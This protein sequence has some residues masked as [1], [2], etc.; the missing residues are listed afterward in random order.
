MAIPT[1]DSS[2]AA[3][4]GTGTSLAVPFPGTVNSGDQLLLTYGVSSATGAATPSGWTLQKTASQGACTAE[5]YTKSASGSETGTLT[6]TV[7]T[8]GEPKL[9]RMYRSTDADSIEAIVSSSASGKTVDHA[10]IVSTD[11]DRLAMTVTSINDDESASSFTSETGGDLTLLVDDTTALD[12]DHGLSLQTADLASAVTLSGGTWAYSGATEQW[13]TIGFAIFQSPSFTQTDKTIN[14]GLVT[15]MA[16]TKF[17]IFVF[18]GTVA[19]P[20]AMALAKTTFKSFALGFVTAFGITKET[21][22]Q[23][24][25]TLSTS[26]STATAIVF[27]KA[28]TVA[29]GTAMA[30]TRTISKGLSMAFNTAMSLAKTTSKTFTVGFTTAMATTKTTLLTKPI[31]FITSMVLSAVKQSA[32][33]KVIGLVT[34]MVLSTAFTSGAAPISGVLMFLFRRRR[35]RRPERR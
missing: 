30:L 15:S 24:T 1:L 31:S 27:T 7:N 5:L 23:K 35:G 13:V 11:T 25:V 16:L 28:V 26:M 34:A 18:S 22:T 21:Q 9:A 20:V 8:D 17:P 3:I 14:F 19:F 10:D 2:A 6:F 33:S 29:F 12:N 4:E 32:V